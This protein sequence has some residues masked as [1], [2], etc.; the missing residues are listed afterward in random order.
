M[1]RTR[2]VVPLAALL[3][4]A[5][6][7]VAADEDGDIRAELRALRERVKELETKLE[8]GGGDLGKAVADFMAAHPGAS[9]GNVSAPGA[10]SLKFY[11]GV[12]MR[13]ERWDRSYRPNDPLGKDVQDQALL[14]T[15]L[16]VDADVT[17][18]LRA[19]VELRD[20]RA[21]GQEP[22]T[23]TELQAAGGG[24]DLKQGWFEAD[25]LL[26]SGWKWRVGRQVLKYGDERVVG[27][28]DWGNYGR[29]F[30]GVLATRTFGQT[31]VDAFA[32]RVFEGGLGVVGTGVENDDAHFF[33]V[34]TTTPHALHGHSDLDVYVLGAQ[35]GFETPGE[36][37]TAG[38]TLY[39][40]A[41]ARLAGG[42]GSWDWSLEAAAQRG[43][44]NGEPLSAYAVHADAGYTWKDSAWKPRFGVE[45]NQATGDQQPASE[46]V[47]SFQTLFPTNHRH[48]GILD[49]MA[50]QNA[51]NYRAS[52]TLRP[53]EK[54]AVQADYHRFYLEETQDAWYSAA[55]IPI[56]AGAKGASSYLGS[57]VDLVFR[58]KAA[59]K[60]DIDFGAAQF[61]DGAFVRQTGTDGDTVWVYVQVTVSF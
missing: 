18:S 50:W 39:G 61:F 40:T 59:D 8:T 23:T 28:N 60:M 33:G 30:D 32:T 47:H 15:T 20:A 44:L 13:A 35:S 25:D 37:G 56:R 49:A 7:A 54:W 34:Y 26:G 11:G 53:S 16:G 9:G 27:D 29:S 17:D 21:F 3:A 43:R 14:R 36:G 55:G 42:K 41:G 12:R 24:L 1:V 51:R 38:T 19:K 52:L 31:K 4:A 48:F 45:W 6:P 57:E 10:K 22:S 46:S 5:S 2:F 58:V